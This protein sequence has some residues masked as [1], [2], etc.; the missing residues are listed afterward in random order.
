MLSSPVSEAVP[1]PASQSARVARARFTVSAFLTLTFL[2]S[3]VFQW[4]LLRTGDPIEKHV[5]LV[6][7]LM[8]TPGLVSLGLRLALREGFADVSFR[9]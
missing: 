5:G 1:Q 7:G 6:L 2:I 8:W 4:L 9:L 3:G